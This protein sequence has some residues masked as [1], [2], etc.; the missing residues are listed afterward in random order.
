MFLD[1]NYLIAI[2]RQDS[3]EA[4]RVE[5]WIL[6]GEPLRV[7]AI[8][9][10]EYLCGPL[11]AAEEEDSAAVLQAIEPVDITVA[12]LGASLFNATGRR[13]R[14]LAD[15]LIAAAAILAQSPLATSNLADFEP[16]IPF[17]LVLA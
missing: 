17:G 6:Q 3:T 1:T 9:W 5:Q 7:S 12:T 11:T 16:F 2:G 10:A 14:S 15:C 4:R 8:A 13:S